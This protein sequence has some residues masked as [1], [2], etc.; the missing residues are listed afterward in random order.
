MG[1]VA[2]RR[3]RIRE[4]LR[5]R[6]RQGYLVRRQAPEGGQAGRR[7]YYRRRGAAGRT[8]LLPGGEGRHGAG[9]SAKGGL[10][11]VRGREQGAGRARAAARE[12]GGL[13]LRSACGRRDEQRPCHI[14]AQRTVEKAAK[15]RRERGTCAVLVTTLD[16]WLVG[17]LY[18]AD[19][20]HL[21]GEHP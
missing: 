13:R 16:G 9:V 19:A 4:G 15:R 3:L 1:R 7:T 20:E 18:R 17:L 5:L 10:G 8:D 14:P 6:A 2:P 11:Q 21:A 12:G